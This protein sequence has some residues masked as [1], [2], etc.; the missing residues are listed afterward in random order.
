MPIILRPCKIP[1]QLEDIIGFDARE[2]LDSPSLQARLLQAVNGPRST[3]KGLLLLDAAERELLHERSLQDHAQKELP[4][5]MR[6]L[7]EFMHIPM[8]SLT[9]NIKQDSLPKNSDTIIEVLLKL[10]R[11]GYH[12][13]MSIFIAK[14]QE[15]RTWPSSLGFEESSFDNYLLKPWPRL[16]VRFRYYSRTVQ[17]S[18]VHKRPLPMTG[19]DTYTTTFDGYVFQPHEKLTMRQKYEIPSLSTA[20]SQKSFFELRS[21]RISGGEAQL[22]TDDTDIWIEVRGQVHQLTSLRIYRS[23][24]SRLQRNVLRTPYLASP[25]M[26]PLVREAL[27]NLYFESFGLPQHSND[28]AM[29]A[30]IEE[31]LETDSYDSDDIQRVAAYCALRT[32]RSLRDKGQIKAAAPQ[33]TK[34][35]ELLWQLMHRND[36]LLEDV[37]Q[38]YKANEDLANVATMQQ[39]LNGA[40]WYLRHLLE[41]LEFAVSKAPEEVD[42]RRMLSRVLFWKARIDL[43]LEIPH[44][45]ALPGLCKSIALLLDIHCKAPIRPNWLAIVEVLGNSIDLYQQKN[46]AMPQL[47]EIWQNTL[48]AL[49]PRE[50]FEE[51]TAAPTPP[52]QLPSWLFDTSIDEMPTK[53]V[54]SASGRYSLRIPESWQSNYALRG[55]HLEIEHIY[56][57]PSDAEWVMIGFADNVDPAWDMTRAIKTYMALNEALPFM[58]PLDKSRDP[59]HVKGSNEPLRSLPSLVAKLNA[60]EAWTMSGV[61][62]VASSGLQDSPTLARYYVLHVRKETFAWRITLSIE[63]KLPP[64]ALKKQLCKDDHLRVGAIL[65][66]LQLAGPSEQLP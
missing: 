47:L 45:T 23:H 22:I 34:G 31:S 21:H 30:I 19:I 9:V 59:Q 20:T 32:A 52:E 17:L 61:Y 35:V 36:L 55:T 6:K 58:S 29:N 41:V 3:P 63:T 4:Q 43:D 24:T 48:R 5:V 37:T 28:K 64:I 49:V 44:K 38:I 12:G 66:P 16:D 54:K 15:G 56:Y 27:L 25:S 18:Y 65:G 40:D 11:L 60:S 33:Y 2:G 53:E 39:N 26:S 7:D 1:A 62:E 57:G 13:T 46:V 51:I 8:H 42:I 14:Y 50:V 10:D